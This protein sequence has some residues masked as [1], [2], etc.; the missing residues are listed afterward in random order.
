[1]SKERR[2]A[3]P[4]MNSKILKISL[5][6]IVIILF[7]FEFI[8]IIGSLTSSDF[9]EMWIFVTVLLYCIVFIVFTVLF[10]LMSFTILT[11]HGLKLCKYRDYIAKDTKKKSIKMIRSF[12]IRTMISS[13]GYV[14]TSIS[15]IILGLSASLEDIHTKIIISRITEIAIG[16]GLTLS[17]ISHIYTYTYIKQSYYIKSSKGTSAEESVTI[18]TN[19]LPAGSID[20]KSSFELENNNA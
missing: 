8:G 12:A 18:S 3:K 14:S 4:F 20:R 7:I 10:I 5:I 2:K 15:I 19:N 9:L 6:I 17:S 11:I 16:L 1:M 13:I